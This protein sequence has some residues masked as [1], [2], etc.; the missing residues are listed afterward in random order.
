[1][2]RAGAIGPGSRSYSAMAPRGCGEG[3]PAAR[4][5]LV[6]ALGVAGAAS[7]A[8]GVTA[9]ALGDGVRVVDR[10][11]G[12]HQALDVVDLRAVEHRGAEAVDDQPDAFLLEDLIGGVDLVLEDHAIGEAGAAAGRDVDAQ[13]GVGGG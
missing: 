5:R 2:A 11:A 12:A 9:T 13:P 6:A 4:R 1:M 7:G 10:E 3:S 8:E